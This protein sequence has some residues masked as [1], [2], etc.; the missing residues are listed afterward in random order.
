M[1][2]YKKKNIGER[3]ENERAMLALSPARWIELFDEE[4]VRRTGLDIAGAGAEDWATNDAKH[5]VLLPAESVQAFM[6]KYD[7]QD[8]T[9]GGW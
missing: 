9:K 2:V 8:L 7:L 1:A 5:G 3:V 6:E 4:L